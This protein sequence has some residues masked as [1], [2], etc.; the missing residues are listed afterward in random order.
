[1][2]WPTIVLACVLLAGCAV[3]GADEAATPPIE[4]EPPTLAEGEE[5]DFAA[6]VL[7]VGDVVRCRAGGLLVE[8]K[9]EALRKWGSKQTTHAWEKDGST[10]SL[11]LDVR[12]TG[13]VLAVCST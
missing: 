1:M 7:A 5:R 3:G 8:A 13:R 10:A 4:P 9:L 2:R 6:G 11:A 12:P